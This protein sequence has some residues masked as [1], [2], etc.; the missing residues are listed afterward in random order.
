MPTTY[1]VNQFNEVVPYLDGRKSNDTTCYRNL[2]GFEE[3]LIEEKS[4]LE[5]SLAEAEE[6]LDNTQQLK[7]EIFPLLTE[8]LDEFAGRKFEHGKHYI[9]QAMA[10]LSAV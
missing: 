3:Q 1:D 6:K 4:D 2:T 8:A 10:K 9:E 5:K 7:A